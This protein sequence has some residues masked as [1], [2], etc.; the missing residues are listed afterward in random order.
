MP[1]HLVSPIFIPVKK[2]QRSW[3]KLMS[4][5][6]MRFLSGSDNEPGG[7]RNF[8][9]PL[10]SATGGRLIFA[11]SVGG[12]T[13]GADPTLPELYRAHFEHFLPSVQVQNGTV[14]IQYHRF[15]VSNWGKPVAQLTLNG[16]IP[17]EIEF[18][19]SV[20]Q[21]TADLSQLPLRALDLSSASQVVIT[22][23]Q[24][25]G[26]V[27]VHVSGSASDITIHRPAGV[28]IRVQIGSSASNLTFDEQH[29]ETAVDGIQWQTPAYQGEKIKR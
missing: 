8:S 27:F 11:S 28:A 4:H 23:P 12:V 1:V 26:T 7:Y 5:N 17:W 9:T 29:F 24:P 22:L 16:T 19:G 6:K 10:G 13:I 21:L 20:S 15:S 3:R 18:R 2:L 25:V 14:S